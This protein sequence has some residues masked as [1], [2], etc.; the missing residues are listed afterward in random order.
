[1]FFFPIP[2]HIQQKDLGTPLITHTLLSA[3]QE[4]FLFGLIFGFGLLVCYLF[5]N[6]ASVGIT[7]P[8]VSQPV[9]RYSSAPLL[10]QSFSSSLIVTPAL[11][12]LVKFKI[13]ARV[14]LCL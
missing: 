4:E 2:F 7:C 5:I 12:S 6:S 13:L 11:V 1:M 10:L 14:P 3:I 9:G 8:K